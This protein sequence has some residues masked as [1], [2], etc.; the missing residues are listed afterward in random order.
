MEQQARGVVV[1]AVVIVGREAGVEAIREA[2][3]PIA[4]AG[5]V[6]I[7]FPL[8]VHFTLHATDQP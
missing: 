8:L 3:Q 2:V 7:R 6:R 1:E 4:I 5:L